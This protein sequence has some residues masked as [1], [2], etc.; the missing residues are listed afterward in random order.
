M[1]E[2][3]DSR[4]ERLASERRS[5]RQRLHQGGRLYHRLGANVLA[6]EL[7]RKKPLYRWKAWQARRQT[8]A[9]V[10]AQPWRLAGGVGVI[11]GIGGWRAFD[12]DQ[13]LTFDAVAQLLATLGL[14][15]D[16]P[17]VVQS[18]SGRGWHV[19][20]VCPEPLPAGALP[21][22]TRDAGVYTAPGRGFDHL[23]LRWQ[24]CY[25]VAPPSLHPS[26]RRYRFVRGRP[27]GAPAVVTP[28]RVAAAFHALTRP[29]DPSRAA[30][31]IAVRLQGVPPRP[32][33]PYAELK[34][35]FDLLA[36]AQE[37]WPGPLADEG[38]DVRVLGYGGLLLRPAR[39]VWYCF[40]DKIGGDAIDLVGYARYGTDWDRHRRGMFHAAVREAAAF[41]GVPLTVPENS[42]G[43]QIPVVIGRPAGQGPPQEVSAH[44]PRAAAATVPVNSTGRHTH[45][46]RR[47]RPSASAAPTPA[48]ATE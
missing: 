9:D 21:A 15:A 16:Y 44:S 38:D 39:G 32:G 26:G 19:W 6:M 14:P 12:F 24:R 41:A 8:T 42:G 20:I 23:E 2:A 35:R 45:T 33:D 34:A 31:G 40:L 25:T 22:K 37:H 30:Q 48:A 28:D 1:G 13:C 47:S 29:R 7:L 36:Y 46:R 3:V 18:G 27:A 4:H 17:W 43:R 11:S 10:A 5:H